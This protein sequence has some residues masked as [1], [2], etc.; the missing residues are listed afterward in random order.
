ML[1]REIFCLRLGSQLRSS[2]QLVSAAFSSE[3][4]LSR[5]EFDRIPAFEDQTTAVGQSVDIG[6]NIDHDGTFRRQCLSERRR[7]R[8]RGLG[9]LQNGGAD[10]ERYAVS[11]PLRLTKFAAVT[12]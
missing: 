4:K 1:P 8:G 7:K 2:H 5:A 11:A 3:R 12:R 9:R 10:G 6:H